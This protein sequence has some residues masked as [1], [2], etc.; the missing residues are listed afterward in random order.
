[1]YILFSIFLIIH[2]CNCDTSASARYTL[3]QVQ[4][5]TDMVEKHFHD[6]YTVRAH[7]NT[8]TDNNVV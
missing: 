5:L 7:R 8:H 3:Y 4:F 6:A 1:M 2:Y